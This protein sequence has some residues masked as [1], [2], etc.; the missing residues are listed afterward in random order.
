MDSTFR[1]MV[2]NIKGSGKMIKDMDKGNKVGLME[3]SLMATTNLMR[4]MEKANFFIQMEI[5]M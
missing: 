2:P 4:K 3:L 5:L 1:I